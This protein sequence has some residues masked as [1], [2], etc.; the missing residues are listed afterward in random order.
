MNSPETIGIKLKECL[1]NV[2]ALT[3]LHDSGSLRD[4]G[5]DSM[6]L[7]NFFLEVETGF[8]IDLSP[9]VIDQNGL[10]DIEKLTT[11]IARQ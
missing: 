11:Y 6:E 8:G 1:K 4:M 9:E 5:L 7:V 2:N 10:Y 3:E